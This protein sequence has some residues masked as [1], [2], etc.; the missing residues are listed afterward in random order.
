MA[1]STQ[2][3]WVLAD[4]P[5]KGLDE[6]LE[7]II[8]DNLLKLKNDLQMSMLIITHD[9]SLAETIC[10]SVVIMYAGQILEINNCFFPKGFSSIQ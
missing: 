9:I 3:K 4:E 6:N 10:D 7:R 2:P 5:T 1:I 8:I